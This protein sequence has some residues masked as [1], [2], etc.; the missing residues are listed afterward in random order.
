[1]H[2]KFCFIFMKNRKLYHFVCLIIF[3]GGLILSGRALLSKS[4]VE[5]FDR[6]ILFML[7]EQL[8]TQTAI[9]YTNLE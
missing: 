9:A 4:I 5:L 7:V 8:P 3:H 1:M 6:L 2:V